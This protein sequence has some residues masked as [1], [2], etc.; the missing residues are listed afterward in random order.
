MSEYSAIEGMG[1][2]TPY[3]SGILGYGSDEEARRAKEEVLRRSE[4]INDELNA[5][6]TLDGSSYKVMP[7]SCY[8]HNAMT[9]EPHPR[10]AFT[11]K[12]AVRLERMGHKFVAPRH[13]A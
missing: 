6:A 9:G 13:G 11:E 12:T 1:G 5:G 3:V 2:S 7:V 4:A 10:T 8:L